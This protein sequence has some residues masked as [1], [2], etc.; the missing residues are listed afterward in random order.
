MLNKTITYLL[1]YLLINIVGSNRKS[2][3]KMAAAIFDFWLPVWSH[4]VDD[5]S[6][7]KLDPENVGVAFGISRLTYLEPE[8]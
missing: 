2:K 1:T 5:N 6:I 4:S 8:I 7:E 3:I